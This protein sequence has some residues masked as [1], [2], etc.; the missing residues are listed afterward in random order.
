MF[1][2]S[3]PGGGKNTQKLS[4][5]S[6]VP[7]GLSPLDNDVLPICRIAL[8]THTKPSHPRRAAR[9]AYGATEMAS[10]SNGSDISSSGSSKQQQ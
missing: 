1:F 10:P 2:I 7:G 6:S 8:V 4:E 5:L 9:T 3:V